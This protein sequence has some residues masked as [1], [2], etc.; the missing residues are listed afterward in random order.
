MD[1]DQIRKTP[2]MCSK[3]VTD[4]YGS[5][6]NNYG[7]SSVP[8]FAVQKQLKALVRGFAEVQSA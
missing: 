7:L 4:A 2:H 1:K 6:S 3:G 5:E 8:N